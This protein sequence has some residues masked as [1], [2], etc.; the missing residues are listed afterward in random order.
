MESC[1][2]VSEMESEHGFTKCVYFR[3]PQLVYAQPPQNTRKLM[4]PT[5]ASANNLSQLQKVS[6][7]GRRSLNSAKQAS[8]FKVPLRIHE[9]F[10]KI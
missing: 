9:F 2:K 8:P 4:F 10:L 7:I 5:A 3:E 6:P 1:I